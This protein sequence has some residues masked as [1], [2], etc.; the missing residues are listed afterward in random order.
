[1]LNLRDN[2][3]IL[4]I[5]ASEKHGL[6]IFILSNLYFITKVIILSHLFSKLLIEPLPLLPHRILAKSMSGMAIDFAQ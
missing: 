6:G 2:L 3:Q 1:M 4:M 5:I